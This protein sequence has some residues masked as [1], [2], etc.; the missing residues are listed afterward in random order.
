MGR[1]HLASS[2][3]TGG[4]GD[5]ASASSAAKH[6]RGVRP[7][8]ARGVLRPAT[9]RHHR[10]DST[11]M[12]ARLSKSRPPNRL[13]PVLLQLAICSGPFSES[14]EARRRS[15]QVRFRPGCAGP[16]RARTSLPDESLMSIRTLSIC[17]LSIRPGPVNPDGGR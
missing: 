4:R 9:C 3:G 7:S 2:K 1:D 14:G 13:A 11:A 5:R 16:R 8:S 17:P 10:S 12:A 15:Q 6:S